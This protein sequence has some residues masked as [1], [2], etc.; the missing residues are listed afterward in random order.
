[1]VE[2]ININSSIQLKTF[3]L[4][5]KNKNDNNVFDY[6]SSISKNIYNSTLYCYKIY[7]QFENNIYKDLH[8]YIIKN[9]YVDKLKTVIDI[10]K[11]KVLLE[12]KIKNKDKKGIKVVK[13][14]NNLVKLE[15][16][17]YEIYDEYYNFYGKNKKI[18]DNNNNIIYK[19]II[20]D[21]K[22]N[23]VLITKNNI[24]NLVNDYKLKII[25]LDNISFNNNNELLVIDNIIF[26]IIKSCYY[27][28]VYYIKKLIDINQEKNIDIKYTD[29]IN[30]VKLSNFYIENY[31]KY[32]SIIKDELG[33]PLTSIQNLIKRVTY[34]HLFENKE[35]IPADVIGNII[36]K[37]YSCISSY[38]DLLK[39]GKQNKTSL[40]R[41]KN[42]EDKFNLFYFCRS[43]KVENDKIR[44]NVGEQVNKIYTELNNI[45]LEKFVK[46]KKIFY[47]NKSDIIES[48]KKLNKKDHEE[49]IKNFFIEKTKLKSFNYIYFNLPKKIKSYEI[50]LI[51]IKAYETTIKIHITY[52]FIIKNLNIENYNLKD[53]NKLSVDD[54]MKKSISIDPGVKNL[55]TIYNPTGKQYII[56]GGKLLSINHF[57]NMKIDKLKSINK[58]VYNKDKFKR[59]YSLEEERRNKISGYFNNLVTQLIKTYSDK[60]IFIMGYNQ[61]WKNKVNM[62][63]KNN[64]NFY[65][66]PYSQLIKKL[67]FALKMR[68]KKL[69]LVKESYTSKCD[70]LAL[71]EIKFHENYEGERILR[72]LFS[73]STKK[74]INSDINGAI[75]IMRKYINLDKI[76]GLC[77]CNP[78]TLKIST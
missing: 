71:E 15:D 39:S 20:E 19:Y 49:I 22:N 75:N 78:S 63:K 14:V 12:K 29:I 26:S 66:I 42:K 61:N 6:M 67:D 57:Y 45:N 33:I 62:G 46:N 16:K 24:T 73:S 17:L 25:K 48:K 56:R 69:L 38:Y 52:E 8:K 70:A 11:K 43:F 2:N 10:N 50:K 1:M 68:N 9:K 23:N 54:K 31:N 64:R 76:T 13:K 36:D 65:Q 60:E 5:H 51:E 77:I 40:C 47:Y 59:L 58:K 41:Y 18:I 21:I 44:L 3:T 55:L 27:K 74:L 7:R 35:K 72:G 30:S 37:T 4:I 32:G 28:T 34:T 53:F